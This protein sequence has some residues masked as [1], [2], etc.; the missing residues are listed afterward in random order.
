[1]FTPTCVIAGDPNATN[2]GIRANG[3]V[4]LFDWDRV[5][6]GIPAHD[7]VVVMP[8]PG[9]PT[10]YQ[11]IAA[12]YL[13]Q[14]EDADAVAHLTHAMALGKVQVLVD[15][16]NAPEITEDGRQFV[17]SQFPSWLTM[18][19]QADRLYHERYG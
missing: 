3:T 19:A 7:V 2:W 9:W 15:Y 17:L 4:V 16:V 1:L 10:F 5:G 18:I 11:Q 14:D 8:Q 12:A 6:Y 13:G